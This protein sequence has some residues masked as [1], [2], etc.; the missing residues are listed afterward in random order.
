MREGECGDV[1]DGRVDVATTSA[2][3]TETSKAKTRLELF[4]FDVCLRVTVVSNDLKSGFVCGSR[5]IVPILWSAAPAPWI[6]FA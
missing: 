4:L 6:P 2:S 3:E 1:R 5:E